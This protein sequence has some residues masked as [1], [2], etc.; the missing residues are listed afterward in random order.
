MIQQKLVDG[1][2]LNFPEFFT[3]GKHVKTRFKNWGLPCYFL[4]SRGQ[5]IK[6]Y[7]KNWTKKTVFLCIPGFIFYGVSWAKTDLYNT[8]MI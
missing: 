7:Y 2:S 3:I 6:K 5:K 4:S 8:Y 1:I